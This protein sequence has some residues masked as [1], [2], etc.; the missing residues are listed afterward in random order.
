MQL[1]VINRETGETERFIDALH[2]RMLRLVSSWFSH[3]N[4]N[5]NEQISRQSPKALPSNSRLSKSIKNIY[6]D[7]RKYDHFSR[8]LIPHRITREMAKRLSFLGCKPPLAARI[9]CR[10]RA[11]RSEQEV[12]ALFMR[13]HLVFESLNN[14]EQAIMNTVL[15]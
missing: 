6:R 12:P 11:T 2:R 4:G 3:S 14:E 7:F 5:D 13:N 9:Y 8:E 10:E 1:E 15:I